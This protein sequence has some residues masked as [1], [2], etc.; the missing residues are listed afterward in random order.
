MVDIT[1]KIAEAVRAAGT[2]E[3]ICTIY[4]PHTTAGLT[5]NEHADPDVAADVIERLEKLVPYQANYAHLEGN[6]DAHIKAVLT[7]NSVQL[8]VRNSSL[9]L[10]TWQ[11][12]FFCEFDGPRQRRVWIQIK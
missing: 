10:G 5:I 9:A 2:E 1:A 7:G 8:I 3:G 11:G 12:I 6:A 4:C